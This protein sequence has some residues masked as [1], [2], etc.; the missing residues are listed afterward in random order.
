[1][2]SAE[3]REKYLKFFEDK[4]HK[5]IPSASLVPENDP[6][7]LFISAGMQPLVPYLL[8]QPH[9]AGTRLVNVQKCIRTRDIDEVGDTFHHTFFEMLG[10]WSLGDYF[11]QESIPWSFEFLTRELDI[12]P[13]KLSVS[14]FAGDDDAPRD[15]EA[16]EIWKNVGIPAARIYYFG[17]E[18]NWWAAGATGPCGPDTEIFYDVTGKPCSSECRPGDNCGRYFE[19]WNN[20]FMVYNRKDDGSLEELPAKNVDTG[21]GL[22]RTIAVLN[23]LDDNYQTDLFLPIIQKIEEITGKKYEDDKKSFRRIADH[24]RASVFIIADGVDPSNTARGYVLRRLIRR[25][26]RY[27]YKLGAKTEMHAE[28]AQAVIYLYSPSY[29]GLKD[30]SERI[31]GILKDEEERFKHPITD[32][33]LYKY[34]LEAAI[35]HQL[36]KKIGEEKIPILSRPGVASGRYVFE[37]YQSFGVPPDLAEETVLELGLK[38]DKKELDQ[39]MAGH[40][41]KSRTASVGMFRGG[42]ATMGETETKYHTA[43]HLLQAAL[44][45]VLGTHV[46][47]MGSNIT[48]E[49]LRFDFSNPKA[50]SSQE[51]ELISEL[52]NQK[53][54]E[55]L[56]VTREVMSKDKALAEGT[57]AFF[58]EKY[59]D[60]VSVYTIGNPSGV[61]FSKEL[62]GGPHV[63]H[64]GEIGRVTITKEESAGSGV[65]RI[66][67]NLE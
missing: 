46:K 48:S 47:Q 30:K 38:F 35:Q 21:M 4:G 40:Q 29:P 14:V 27:L 13:D 60:E 67:A 58:K 55:D 7:T 56:L 36:I 33:E 59:P 34:D 5:I 28:I 24:T 37:N 2:T 41:E 31:F 1:M 26:L 23:G 19:I 3:L 18:D 64:T 66:Y 42:L 65:R 44:R 8:G 45:Q 53:I 32:L 25:A 39:A 61:W 9:S 52:V 10:N 57:L 20:V 22:E 49:R 16:A 63:G 11:K 62:C 15:A 12:S 51:V 17:K 50:L 6:S 43:T 54:V